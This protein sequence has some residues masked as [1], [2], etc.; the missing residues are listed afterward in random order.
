MLE[1]TERATETRAL[2]AELGWDARR[3]NSAICYLQHAGVIEQRH[4]LANKPW[5]A[6][7]LIRTDQTLRFARSRS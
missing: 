3:M 7:H 6:V 4:A 2:A 5:R 1:G